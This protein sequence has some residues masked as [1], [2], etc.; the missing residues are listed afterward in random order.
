MES[1]N[2]SRVSEDAFII[3]PTN[4]MANKTFVVSVLL[5]EPY[6]MLKEEKHP[7]SGNDRY[8]GFSIDM[9]DE[10]ARILM[11]NVSY[12]IVRDGKYGGLDKTTNKWNGAIGEVLDGP[13]WGGADF[14]AFD[15][16]ITSA[17]AKAIDFSMPFLNLGISIL[18]IKPR[19]A[20]PSLMAFMEPFTTEVWI[21]IA[22]G[23]QQDSFFKQ[24]FKL[25]T[26]L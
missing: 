3:D 4:I 5:N 23:K 21:Y 26:Y 13:E 16:T 1:L 9:M 24:N 17:R 19:Q 15:L 2:L 7:L 14:A 6:A 18:F 25:D 20:P 8:E 10:I 12:K 22:L 11:F